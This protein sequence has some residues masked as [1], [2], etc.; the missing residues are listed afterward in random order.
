MDF[1]GLG[2]DSVGKALVTQTPGPE[3]I[4]AALL[5]E[6]GCDVSVVPLR[7]GRGDNPRTSLESCPS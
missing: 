3:F 7:G 4:F 1:Q 2:K 5:S 6:A